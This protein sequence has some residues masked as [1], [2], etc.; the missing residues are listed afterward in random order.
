MNID[1][2]RI[3]KVVIVVKE[4]IRKWRIHGNESTNEMNN[5]WGCSLMEENY[6]K[7]N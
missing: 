5:F 2:C 6:F 1:K 7:R 3:M 4:V